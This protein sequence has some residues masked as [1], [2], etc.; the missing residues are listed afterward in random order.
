[1]SK[2]IDFFHNVDLL[3]Y[4]ALLLAFTVLFLPQKGNGWIIFLVIAGFLILF[5]MISQYGAKNLTKYLTIIFLI[6]ILLS[7]IGSHEQKV[8]IWL[9]G[10]SA[11]IW[12]FQ[13]AFGKKS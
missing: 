8:F 11:L 3:K 5:W 4:L 1:M 9:G 10:I 12:I 13:I 6:L 7:N 2:F